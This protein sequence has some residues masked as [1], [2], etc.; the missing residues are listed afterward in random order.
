MDRFPF[1]LAMI[2]QFSRLETNCPVTFFVGDNGSGKSTL[3]ESIA[4]A[5][6]LVSI[7]SDSLQFDPTLS[8]Q[9][10]LAK[11]LRLAWSRKPHS[12]FFLRAEDFF[13]FTKRLAQERAAMEQALIELDAQYEGRSELALTLAKAPLKKSL[14]AWQDRYGADLDA[15]SH[16]QS[17]LQVFQSRFVPN[18]LYLL[19]EPETPLSFNGQLALISLIDAMVKQNGQFIIATHS[20]L[21]LAYP[22]AK[23]YSFDSAPLQETPY[24]DIEYVKLTRSFLHDPQQFLRHLVSP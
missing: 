5:A 24:D 21:L 9:K 7:G 20:P 23:I 19:D 8:A 4:I 14:N 12:G 2:Q 13:G 16:G 10:Q 17:F 6:N 18:G 11:F 1:N 22:N 15:N 3:L